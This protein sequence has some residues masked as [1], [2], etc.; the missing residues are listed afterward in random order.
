MPVGTLPALRSPV[1]V[2]EIALAARAP[3]RAILVVD[4][5]SDEPAPWQAP[6]LAEVRGWAFAGVPYAVGEPLQL[7]TLVDVYG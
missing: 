4:A 6:A 1:L 2:P 7:G 5:W 3:A